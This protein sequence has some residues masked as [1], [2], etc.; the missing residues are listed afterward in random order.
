M[1]RKFVILLV[2]LVPML[3]LSPIEASDSTAQRSQM[4]VVL[5][6]SGSMWGQVDGQTKIQIVREAFGGLVDEW[7]K[8][9]V[10]AGLVVY[11][12]RTKGDCS[13]IQV[14]AE[15]GPVD[16]EQL[17]R[18]VAQLN[19]KGKTPL[20]DAVRRAAEQLKYTEKKATVILLSDGRETCGADPCKLG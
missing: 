9:S 2:G 15:P 1:I 11:G 6:A 18:S 4:M 17:K 12:H 14:I 20:V 10:D 19:P 7:A 16:A 5:D 3:T 13:D 8:Q